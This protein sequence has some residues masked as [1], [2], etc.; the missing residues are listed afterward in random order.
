[1]PVA[2]PSLLEPDGLPVFSPELVLV[3]PEL[4][5]LARRVL[6]DVPPAAAP[7]ERV[8]TLPAEIGSQRTVPRRA[9]TRAVGFMLCASIAL[10][11]LVLRY[12]WDD[13]IR[14]GNFRAIAS[15]PV[16]TSQP[17]TPGPHWESRGR[18]LTEARAT[19]N[20]IDHGRPVWPQ[21][22]GSSLLSNLRASNR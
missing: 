11:V 13:G 20:P 1:M 18:M 5:A 8:P 15:P 2:D 22:V 9:R 12:A 7:H 17:Q 6:Q 21:S 16:L 10:N 4:A 3:D 19:S 14:P